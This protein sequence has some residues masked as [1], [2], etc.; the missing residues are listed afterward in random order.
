MNP[1]GGNSTYYLSDERLYEF[2][3]LTPGQRLTWVEQCSNFIRL[4]RLS[5]QAKQHSADAGQ[6]REQSPCADSPRE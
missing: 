3:K 2:S 1:K 4:A 5:L 6:E